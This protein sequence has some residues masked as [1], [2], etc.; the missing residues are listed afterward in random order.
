MKK[1]A[2]LLVNVGTPDKPDIGAVRRYL[3]E[4]LNDRRVIDIPWLFQKIL[5]NLIIIPFR[6]KKSTGLYKRLWTPEGSPLLFYLNSLVEKLQKKLD[7]QYRVY[8]AMRYGNPSLKNVLKRIKSDGIEE[9][10]VL[11]LYPQYASS[12]TGSVV[13]RIFEIT[14]KWQAIPAIGVVDQFYNHSAFIDAFTKRIISY[15]PETYDH[16]IFSYH[17][18]PMRQINKIHPSVSGNQCNCI[19]EMPAHGTF[20]YKATCYETTRLLINKL[21]LEAKTTTVSFQSRLSNNWLEP[22]T[23]ATI[24]SLAQS[25]ARRI[26][27]VAPAFVA[28]CLETIVEIEDYSILFKKHGGK[29]LVLVPSLNDD[30]MWVEGILKI[31]RFNTPL[32]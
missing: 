6:V 11:P 24:I 8:G 9:V 14:A 1:Y 12:T 30:D 25:G 26:L 3:S 5:V 32:N 27:L 20:C 16:I 7:K 21:N 17:G 15:K 13:E 29:E 22:F 2:L 23:D 4:F 10:I 31:I 18:L 28:D 19:H